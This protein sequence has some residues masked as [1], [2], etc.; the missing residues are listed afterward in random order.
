M[1][2]FNG[3]NTQTDGCAHN[4]SLTY[5]TQLSH[6]NKR[7]FMHVY[8]RN[9]TYKWKYAHAYS[10]TYVQR[11]NIINNEFT[12]EDVSLWLTH[13]QN[14][15]HLA[16]ISCKWKQLFWLEV[17]MKSNWL[18]LLTNTHLWAY[19]EWFISWC[20]PPFTHVVQRVFFT[21]WSILC[22]ISFF[23]LHRFFSVCFFFNSLNNNRFNYHL[24]FELFLKNVSYS[25]QGCI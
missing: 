20:Y 15:S 22:W 24:K 2:A 16:F 8:A 3:L 7:I 18:N 21:V 25:H 10:N 11:F 9:F 1:N 19:F 17:N 5:E 12:L 13:I 23:F 4:K 14:V 6:A